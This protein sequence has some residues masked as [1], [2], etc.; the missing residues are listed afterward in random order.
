M[1]AA[2]R[3]R[4]PDSLSHRASDWGVLGVL[5]AIGVTGY[6]VEG[7]RI[8]GDETYMPAF[9]FVGFGVSKAWRLVGVDRDS[10][11]V[12]HFVLWWLHA[13]LALGLI[14]AF[15]YTRLLH[16]I[17]GS[18]NLTL[19]AEPLGTMEPISIEDL[20]ETGRVG[21]GAIE[22]FSRR[23]LLML[24]ACVACGRCEE[25]CPAYE[26]GKTAVAE[27]SRTG[28]ACLSRRDLE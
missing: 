19:P 16:V 28:S 27:E 22:H 12:I 5:F 15:P 24:D 10:A 4:P 23:Q 6:L 7:A 18:I 25:S 20:E 26:A 9:S 14:A 3:L 1:L 11:Q 8:I 21:V 2:R 17:A 13:F